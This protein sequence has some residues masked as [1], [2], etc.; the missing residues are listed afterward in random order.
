MHEDTIPTPCA[1]AHDARRNEKLFI[2]LIIS[3]ELSLAARVCSQLLLLIS[4]SPWGS[5]ALMLTEHIRLHEAH[6][7][8]KLFDLLF[9]SM[10]H[11]KGSSQTGHNM[12]LEGRQSSLPGHKKSL[13]ARRLSDWSHDQAKQRTTSRLRDVNRAS[14]DAKSR[15][16]AQMER[17]GERK[18]VRG[19]SIER[20]WAQE[21]H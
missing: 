1:R 14:Q 20:A 4:S 6:R 7:V 13:K 17:L 3:I 5:D 11:S 15:S 2:L 19:A 10:S 21:I 12:S 18:I 8:E 9:F 16:R